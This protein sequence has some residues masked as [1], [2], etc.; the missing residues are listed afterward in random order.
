MSIAILFVKY[1]DVDKALEFDIQDTAKTGRFS[2]C[3]RWA[4]QFTTQMNSLLFMHIL[5]CVVTFYREIYEANIKTVG[6]FM[7]AIE[8]LTLV[9]VV[10]SMVAAVNSYNQA[11]PITKTNDLLI[12]K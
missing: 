4:E 9:F 8:V 3:A 2:D 10:G 6:H 12:I 5:C 11:L 1:P 7:R